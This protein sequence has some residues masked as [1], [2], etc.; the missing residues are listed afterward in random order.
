MGFLATLDK[1]RIATVLV[2]LLIAF[3]TGH[4]M[5]T[6]LADKEPVAA[7]NGG[8][9]AAPVLRS[10]EDPKPLPTPP[11]ATLMPILER[12]PLLP[13]RVQEPM[14]I[15]RDAKMAEPDCTASATA[16][17][18][19]AATVTLRIDAPC[20]KGATVRV[21]QGQIVADAY[22][23]AQGKLTMR[24]P[25]LSETV[26]FE[27]ELGDKLI[28]TIAKVP[29]APNFQH[30]ALLWTGKQA[31]R[32]HAYE[33]GALKNQFGHVW[34]GAPKSPIRASRGSGGFLLRLGDG[35]G[36]SAEIYS[37]PAGQAPTRGIIRLIVEAQ[38]TKENCGHVIQATALQ[39]GALGHLSPTDVEYSMPG[40]DS[41][42]R[43]VRL[44]NLLQDMRL[45][46]R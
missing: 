32:L 16:Q 11:A 18:S 24:M 44:Q 45:A 38:V 40:C 30:V 10:N 37:F 46:E 6:V 35:T 25:A 15:W 17:P 31:L 43:I 29:E 7:I 13:R 42:G 5:Q 34:S 3:L 12:P 36:A 22:T 9:D 33:F 21:R 23:N 2:V 28:R 1:R 8:P 39:S 4:V 20:H 19:P 27:V 41:I 14:R 26:A